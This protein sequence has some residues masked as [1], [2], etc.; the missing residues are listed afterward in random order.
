VADELP[1]DSVIYRAL[2]DD[3][4]HESLPA[5][6]LLM[7]VLSG[8]IDAVSI[9]SLG[10]V[11]VANMTGNLV[12]SGFSLAGAPGFSVGIAMVA[13]GTFIIGAVACRMV[14][15]SADGADKYLVLR[16]GAALETLLLLAAMAISLIDGPVTSLA[17]RYVLVS[18]CAVAMGVQNGVASRL[19][20]PELT[21]TVMTRGLISIVNGIGKRERNIAEVRLAFA[22]VTLV[23]GAVLGAVLVRQVSPGA[24]L[25]LAAALGAAVTGLAAVSRHRLPRPATSGAV[26]RG[27]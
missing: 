8:T 27:R 13:F 26:D 11:F 19:A 16:D 14:I 17:V 3:P 9:L 23:G 1:P 21:T 20:V 25:G 15:E 7:T 6:L 2:L 18:I 24:A 10:H 5:L 12:F 22:L 4:Q